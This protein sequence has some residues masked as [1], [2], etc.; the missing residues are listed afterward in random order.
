MRRTQ[1][2]FSLVAAIV[3]LSCGGAENVGIAECD[4][5]AQI[6]PHCGFQNPE[7][8]VLAPGGRELVV[9]EIGTF[10]EATPG[11]LSIFDLDEK[12]RIPLPI[13]WDPASENWGDPTCPKPDAAALSPHGIDLETRPDGRHALFVVNHGG[14]ESVEIFE[15]ERPGPTWTLRWRGCAV[16]PANAL[17]ND[18]TALP[19][20][21]FAVTHMWDQERSM[22][23]MAM[24]F[25]LGLDTGWVWEWQAASGFERMPGSEGSMPNGIA[26][27]EDGRFVFVNHYVDNRTIKLDRS[28][29]EIVGQVEVEQPD[30]VSMDEAGILWIASHQTFLA[31]SSCSEIVGA[32][33]HPFSIMRVDSTTMEGNNVFSHEGAPMGFATVAV[34]AGDRLFMGSAIG[35]RLISIPLPH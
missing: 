13:D 1:F 29:G 33:P 22:P 20:G 21:G 9:S 18:V 28:T 6:E 12:A 35:D 5:L 17:L 2:V 19:D 32:C 16:P 31:D 4:P 25:I 11:Q 15:L 14:R 24:S 23:F 10:L 26:S 3:A 8:L 27:S 30:N 34:P 7:D